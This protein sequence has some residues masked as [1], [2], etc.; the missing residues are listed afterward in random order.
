M[1]VLWIKVV[2]IDVDGNPGSMCVTDQYDVRHPS[3]RTIYMRHPSQSPSS[4]LLGLAIGTSGLPITKAAAINCICV[5]CF[6]CIG[7]GS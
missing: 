5:N 7:E 2:A 6:I 1:Q 4:M 3:A